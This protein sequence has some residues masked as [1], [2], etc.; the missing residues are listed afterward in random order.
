MILLPIP[1]KILC[2]EYYVNTRTQAH[3]TNDSEE[4]ESAYDD[5]Y[6]IMTSYSSMHNPTDTAYKL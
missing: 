6:K 1:L 5:Y 4:E 2:S 3:G